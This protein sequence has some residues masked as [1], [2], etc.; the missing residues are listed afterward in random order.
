MANQF[1]RWS[2]IA[3]ST[4]QLDEAGWASLNAAWVCDDH[5]KVTDA[6]HCREK[7]IDLF[8]AARKQGISFAEDKKTETVILVDLLRMCGQFQDA[9]TICEK[10]LKHESELNIKKIMLFQ[11][12]LIEKKGHAR[13]LFR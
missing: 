1:L 5:D 8:N 2:I 10:A 13:T 6:R 4:D 12:D 11:I 7:A 9:N 3:K